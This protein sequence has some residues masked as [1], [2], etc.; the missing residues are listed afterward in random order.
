L[1]PDIVAVGSPIASEIA[2][3]V[4]DLNLTGK[5]ADRTSALSGG[6]KRALSVSLALVGGSKFVVLD[7]PTSGVERMLAH[8]PCGL[9]DGGRSNAV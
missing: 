4:H 7:E 8:K 2:T 1:K 5:A 9:I 6:Q 3:F